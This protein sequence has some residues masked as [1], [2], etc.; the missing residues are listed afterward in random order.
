MT[1]TPAAPARL[2][3]SHLRDF[4]EFLPVEKR[5]DFNAT[6]DDL[7]D[8]LATAYEANTA[9]DRALLSDSAALNDVE[10]VAQFIESYLPRPFTTVG[11]IERATCVQAIRALKKAAPQSVQEQPLPASGQRT[12]APERDLVS[13]ESAPNN[14]APLSPKS[15]NSRDNAPMVP[16][17]IREKS[18]AMSAG[19]VSV[20]REPTEAMRRAAYD[21]YRSCENT[22]SDWSVYVYRAMLAAAPVAAEKDK[23]DQRIGPAGR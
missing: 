10:K 13:A 21:A 16:Q 11:I 2:V 8:R 23:H 7:V 6:I 19:C 18:N 17:T 1:A 15:E 3:A 5:E 14:A 9:L 22:I 12:C 4:A 20:P